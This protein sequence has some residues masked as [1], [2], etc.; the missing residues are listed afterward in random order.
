MSRYTVVA[1]RPTDG[2][3]CLYSKVYKNIMERGVGSP[4]RGLVV[5]PDSHRVRRDISRPPPS[6]LGSRFHCRRG[7]GG[8]DNPVDASD[9]LVPIVGL[10]VNRPP[11]KRREGHVARAGDGPAL[12]EGRNRSNSPVD[13]HPPSSPSTRGVAGIPFVDD[14]TP[15][16]STLSGHHR[17]L[18]FTVDEGGGG[19]GRVSPGEAL[20]LSVIH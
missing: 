19:V 8:F 10:S 3:C 15:P 13:H 18:S 5:N 20:S 11:E 17:R 6:P 14:R 2:C 16:V 7:G 1:T 12:A 4:S 9:P